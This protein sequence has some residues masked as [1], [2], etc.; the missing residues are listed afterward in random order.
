MKKND[1]NQRYYFVL[2]LIDRKIQELEYRLKNEIITT[3]K[4]YDLIKKARHDGK[5]ASYHNVAASASWVRNITNE[6]DIL[7]NLKENIQHPAEFER[8]A[9]LKSKKKQRG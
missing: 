2:E 7:I 4:W 5:P 3:K 6:V 9:G 1:F 8:K